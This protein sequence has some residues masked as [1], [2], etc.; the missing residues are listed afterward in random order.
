MICFTSFMF[1]LSCFLKYLHTTSVPSVPSI[2]A[3]PTTAKVGTEA[4]IK[5]A[6]AV[7]LVKPFNIALAPNHIP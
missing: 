7:K 1:L 2:A 4:H 5:T 3:S 6:P